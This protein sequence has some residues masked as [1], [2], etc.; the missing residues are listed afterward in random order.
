M[1]VSG[2]TVGDCY[3]GAVITDENVIRPFDR[4]LKERAGFR[5][6]TGNIFHSAVMK[7]S[8]VSDEFRDRYL[9]NPEHP[10]AFEGRAVVFDGPED[11]HRRIDDPALGDRR[12]HAAVHARR[13]A[14]G[15][16]GRGRGREH[17]RARLPA[18]AGGHEPR[19]RRRRPAVGDQ[20]LAV[21]PQ[22]L[23]RG[24]VER[25]R[26]RWSRPA[27]GCGSTSTPGGSTCWSTT[28]SWRAG[29]RALEA[30]GGYRYPDAPDAVAGDPARPRRRARDRR[31]AGAGGQV[32][33]DRPDQGHAARQP[34]SAGDLAR[35]LP[36]R[37]RR[38]WRAC[39]AP[40]VGRAVP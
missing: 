3:A 24:G 27:T 19:L 26:W 29:A 14:E 13:R 9:S 18:E 17:A 37:L 2:R 36:S 15:L 38:H 4:P 39:Q 28:T 33:A 10:N 11:Y 25:R 16:S 32:P 12:E 40:A 34:L 30:A 22:R 1:T 23:A 35:P 6:L 21:D 31:G 8:V 7:M 5:V 20:R